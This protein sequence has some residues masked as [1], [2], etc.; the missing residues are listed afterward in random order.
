MTFAGLTVSEALVVSA[1]TPDFEVDAGAGV[2]VVG[3]GLDS[4]GVELTSSAVRALE[5]LPMTALSQTL[6]L[7]GLVSRLA[8]SEA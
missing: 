7:K 1:C 8:M 3:A 6:Q 4:S 5:R 2:V